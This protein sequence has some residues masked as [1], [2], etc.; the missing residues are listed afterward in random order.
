MHFSSLWMP[1]LIGLVLFGCRDSVI[2]KLPPPP[3]DRGVLE[4]DC[5]TGHAIIL[6]DGRTVAVCRKPGIHQFILPKGRYLLMVKAY[7]H[8]SQFHKVEI[9]NLSATK[10]LIE[11]LK[12]PP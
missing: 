7:G 4:L 10:L 2:V 12:E 6:N 11:L 1:V 5:R 9:K 8:Y 3:E